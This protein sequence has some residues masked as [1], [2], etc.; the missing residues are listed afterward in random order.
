MG[1]ALLPPPEKL[2]EKKHKDGGKDGKDG[3]KSKSKEQHGS[4]SHAAPVTGLGGSGVA[5]ATALAPH[6][7]PGAAAE[8][9]PQNR[10]GA[11]MILK[12][13]ERGQRSECCCL[14]TLL[15]LHPP[16]SARPR[17]HSRGHACMPLQRLSTHSPTTTCV[18]PPP[19]AL[20]PRA[21][22]QSRPLWNV[23]PSAWT[24][25][26]S[27]PRQRW[28]GALAIAGQPRVLAKRLEAG[29]GVGSMGGGSAAPVRPCA[30][31]PTCARP[32]MRPSLSRQASNMV[33]PGDASMAAPFTAK[34][35]SVMP[36]L[37]ILKQGRCT[38]V[39]SSARLCCACAGPAAPAGS[40]CWQRLLVPSLQEPR[41]CDAVAS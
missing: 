32:A 10:P 30:P 9:P 36:C 8:G 3:K 41:P 38:L 28:V 13:R 39:S 14:A 4:G 40:A 15:P 11:M 20:F 5:A 25:W 7:N 31:P 37:D 23:W 34:Q 12:M 6:H 22:L 21:C 1:V 2:K 33:R 26:P 35:S 18:R 24:T 16:W 19:S 27:P 29:G 17:H